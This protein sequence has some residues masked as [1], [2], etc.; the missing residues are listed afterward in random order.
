M[1]KIIQIL[2]CFVIILC[3]SCES[4]DTANVSI[5]TTYPVITIEGD[6]IYV[7][8]EGTPYTDPGASA[9][10][11][12]DPVELNVA[13]DV[14]VEAPGV[15]PILYS[16]TNSDGFSRAAARQVVVFD[17]ATDATDLSGDYIRAATGVIAT[18]IK[19]GPS[20]YHINDAGGLGESFLDVIFVHVE[21]DDLVIPLQTAPSSGIVVAS[22]PESAYITDKGFR[23]VLSASSVYGSAVRD[24]TK[25]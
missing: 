25:L 14:D 11:G 2:F 20:T 16:A 5:V 4:D 18:V 23:W 24:F 21:G 12:E 1:K 3:I 9:K 17:P 19:I 10:V 22:V 7:T 13:G 8:P 6:A 15:Y